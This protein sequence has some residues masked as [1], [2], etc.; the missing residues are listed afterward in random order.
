MS[1]QLGGGPAQLA[2]CLAEARSGGEA[3]RGHAGGGGLIRFA[4]RGK[5]ARQVGGEEGPVPGR[6]RAVGEVLS[7][8]VRRTARLAGLAVADRA[9]SHQPVEGVSGAERP[10]T[11][12]GFGTPRPAQG[13]VG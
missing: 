11:A 6:E 4:G 7:E 1:A 5:S 12:R 13:V 9:L 3:E 10:G 2:E 8:Q